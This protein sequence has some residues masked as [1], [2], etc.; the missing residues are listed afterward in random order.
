MLIEF[1]FLCFHRVI[2][3]ILLLVHF[4]FLFSMLGKIEW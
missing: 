3:T 1:L 4:S 2:S